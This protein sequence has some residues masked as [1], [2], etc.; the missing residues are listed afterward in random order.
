VCQGDFLASLAH[1]FGFDADTIWKDPKNAQLQQLRPNPNIL[2]ATDILYIPL[3]GA[4]P[5]MTNLETGSMNSFVSDPPTVT[6]THTFVGD[7][8]STYASQAYTIQE[9]DSLTGLTTDGSGTLTFKAP[10][11][12]QA[13][14]IVFTG[15]G[16]T[17]ALS[18]GGLDPIDTLS[19]VFQRLQNLGYIGQDLPFDPSNVDLIR[20]GLVGLKGD[21]SSGATPP[22][23]P[24]SDSPP[25]SSPGGA[26]SVNDPGSA[27]G[28]LDWPDLLPGSGD[29]DPPCDCSG[30]GSDGTLDDDTKSLLLKVYGV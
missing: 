1:Q 23:A 16:E 26:S 29:D 15:T 9:L 22:S 4:P 2:Y 24:A 20:L 5:A 18:I 8:P 12:M 21:P 19:G 7:D 11:S 17:W 28:A 27:T 14:T 10:V 6:I 25:A 30:L 13:A 3:Q